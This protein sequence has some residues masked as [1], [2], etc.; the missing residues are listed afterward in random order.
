MDRFYINYDF[1]LKEKCIYL[2][3]FSFFFFFSKVF[4][5]DDVAKIYHFITNELL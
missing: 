1:F 2:S 5:I 4:W 3:L